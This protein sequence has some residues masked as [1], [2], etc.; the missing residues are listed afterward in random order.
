MRNRRRQKDVKPRTDEMTLGQPRVRLTGQ[1]AFL[2]HAGGGACSGCGT[3]YD[4]LFPDGKGP[5]C[6]RVG[7]DGDGAGPATVKRSN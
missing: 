2:K 5:C 6:H 7:P 3:R 1:S 4:T